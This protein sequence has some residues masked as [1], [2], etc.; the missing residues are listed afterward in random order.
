MSIKSH[1]LLAD[2]ALLEAVSLRTLIAIAF[3]VILL[4]RYISYA[5]GK[6]HL[7]GP[8]ALPIFGN[9]LSLGEVSLPTLHSR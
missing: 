7:P 2:S 9:L 6:V 4:A 1:P 5:R 8:L 3:G